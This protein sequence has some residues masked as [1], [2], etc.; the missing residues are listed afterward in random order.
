MKLA[1][2]PECK[3]RSHRGFPLRRPRWIGRRSAFVFLAAATAAPAR[4]PPAPGQGRPGGQDRRGR[5][6]SPRHR[7]PP[8][9]RLRS[10][11]A[12]T[13]PSRAAGADRASA[14]P[15]RAPL[16]LSS[17]VPARRGAAGRAGARLAGA[18]PSVRG[19]S[20]DRHDRAPVEPAGARSPP[21]EG[22]DPPPFEKASMPG[23]S[24]RSGSSTR[25]GPIP[26]RA[27]S[28]RAASTIRPP[29]GWPAPAPD[30]RAS[31]PTHLGPCSRFT[32]D[33]FSPT[34]QITGQDG[35]RALLTVRGSMIEPAS[36][37]GRVVAKGTVFQPLR[38]ISTRWQGRRQDIP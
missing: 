36:P 7:L 10:E 20:L 13:A 34:A 11:P 25:T 24:I 29:D 18:G 28:S 31:S 5:R 3:R 2:C 26:A 8:R 19:D 22:T 32:L 38:L 15:D 23:H 21:G 37:I 1:P 30:G 16:R 9:R 33:L 35:G 14:L 12:K 6:R 17:V 4:R 27:W